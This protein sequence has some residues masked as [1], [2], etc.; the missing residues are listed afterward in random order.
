MKIPDPTDNIELFIFCPAPKGIVMRCRVSRDKKGVDRNMYPTYYLHM[1]RSD[2]K[3]VCFITT[4][5]RIFGT[6]Q[7]MLSAL[8]AIARPSVRLSVTRV[9][10]SKAVKVTIMQFSPYSSPIPLLFTIKV[11]SRN[12]DGIYTRAGASNNGGLRPC[13]KRAIF[14][15]LTLSLGGY[16]S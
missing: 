8:Y 4:L 13:G 5:R 16:S 9:D 3:K 15:V 6:R 2:G 14:V 1:E 7:H 10:Q 11:S 12:A